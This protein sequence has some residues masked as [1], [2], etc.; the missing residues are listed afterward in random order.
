MITELK[1]VDSVSQI[2]NLLTQLRGREVDIDAIRADTEAIVGS[3]NRTILVAMSDDEIIGMA[4]IN[5]VIKVGKRE[6]RIDEVVVD[7]S[8]RGTGLGRKLMEAAIN[9]AWDKSCNSIELT[10]KPAREAANKLYQKLGFEIRETNVYQL[11]K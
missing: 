9:W 1:N 7:E 6:A 5:I 3:S 11:K 8:A 10:S 4:V 2:A